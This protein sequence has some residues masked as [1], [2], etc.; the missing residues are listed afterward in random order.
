MSHHHAP[1]APAV[2]CTEFLSTF[3]GMTVA[4]VRDRQ[5]V[6]GE[7]VHVHATDDE[8][9]P[10]LVVVRDP[11]RRELRDR[12]RFSELSRAK[13]HHPNREGTP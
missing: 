12:V 10:L 6:V 5:R 3:V 4:L 13:L 2:S 8:N 11:A 1:P 7:L 9:D